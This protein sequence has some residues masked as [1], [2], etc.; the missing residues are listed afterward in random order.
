MKY[1]TLKALPNIKAGTVFEY[2]KDIITGQYWVTLV[3]WDNIGW[4]LEF[5]EWFWLDND[6][7]EKV[8]EKR[9]AVPVA[10]DEIYIISHTW[11]I[12]SCEYWITVGEYTINQWNWRWTQEEAELEVKKRAAIERVRR[13]IV[14]NGLLEDD[15]SHIYTIIYY[16]DKIK[17]TS[18]YGCE[19]YY[20]PYGRIKN[21]DI[22]Q[23]IEDCREDLLIIHS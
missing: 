2:N 5:V 17:N 21:T 12:S 13:Y 18:V 22:T 7:F 10:H 23:F 19:S 9:K 8:E 6:F 14:S 16:E 11:F 20:S 3:E 1:K 15:K 4:L